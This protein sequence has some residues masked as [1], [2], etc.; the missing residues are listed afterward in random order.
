MR[1]PSLNLALAALLYGAI[2]LA[3]NAG[4]ALT[5]AERAELEALR[6]GDMARLIV[7]EA[8]RPRVETAFADAAGNRL[9]LADFAGKVVLLNVWATWCPPC[10]AEMPALDRLQGALAGPEFEVIA[11]STD[12]AGAGRVEAFFADIGVRNLAIRLDRSGDFQQAAGV[13][14]LPATLILDREGREIARMMGDADW[15][16][17]E[18]QALI[19]RLIALTRPREAVRT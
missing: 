1:R 15:D 5:P 12:R 3:A 9:T 16:G 10:R 7:H 19:E 17:P 4:L 18:A 14:G 11:L 8:P 6:T 13:L 2:A